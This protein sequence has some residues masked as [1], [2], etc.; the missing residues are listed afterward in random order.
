MSDLSEVEAFRRPRLGVF[1]I[2]VHLWRSIWLML[3]VFLPI[4]ALGMTF[5]FMQEDT[6]VATSRVK[7]SAGD[8]YLFR[9]RVGDD[10][11]NNAVPGIEE[12][13]QT[14]IELMYSPVV[15]ER[16]LQ[17]FGIDRLYP[18]LAEKLV[19]ADAQETYEINERA[20]ANLRGD[21]GAYVQ[22]KKSVI[23]TNFEHKDA[24]LSADVLNAILSEYIDYRAGI[25]E[26]EDLASFES[27]RQSFERDLLATEDEMRQF[28]AENEIGNFA[29]EQGSVQ[30]LF[31]SIEQALF[32]N[33]S[34]QSE[35]EGQLVVLRQQLATTPPEIDV[36]V[37]DSS[38]QSLVTLELERQQLLS[39]YTETSEPVKDIDRRIARARQY[40]DGGASTNGLVRRGPNPL[41]QSVETNHAA[42]SAQLSAARQQMRALNRQSTEVQ[43]RQRRL[44]ELEPQWQALVRQRD[45]LESNART[46]A[47]RETESRALSQFEG[48][49]LNSIKILELARRPAE[50][51]S[52]KLVIAI[53]SLL[54][55]G[56]TALVV[57]L[58][59]ALSFRGFVSANS[60]ERTTGLPVVSTVARYK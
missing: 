30:T 39:R 60:I 26:N 21:F 47:E 48:Q 16:V 10:L 41:Y 7:V 28:L 3:L 54:F 12:L 15:S 59:R 20:V 55:A 31:G 9:P 50:G 57:G 43:V 37:E 46:F 23:N 56:F 52:L 40:L 44:A 22:P 19:G 17:Q 51:S 2:G 38:N 42:L 24:Q 29:T 13:V 35:L 36:F 45:L 11:L 25:F 14:E 32:T 58:L 49:D 33:E 34:V 6:Y 27:Q 53:L 1:E 8:E 5:A 18:E 4:F